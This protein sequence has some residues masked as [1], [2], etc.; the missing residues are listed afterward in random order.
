MILSLFLELAFEPMDCVAQSIFETPTALFQPGIHTL[1]MQDFGMLPYGRAEF[2]S[3]Y[4]IGLG[5]SNFG[6]E[7]YRE[8]ELV[9][10]YARAI[11]IF[12]IGASVRGMK[13]G[14]KGYNEKSAIS[15]GMGVNLQLNKS[16]DCGITVQNVNSPELNSEIIPRTIAYDFTFHPINEF[17][18]TVQ[19]YTQ[20]Y[21]SELR[22]MNEIKLSD[23]LSLNIG[24]KNEPVSFTVGANFNYKKLNIFYYTRTHPELGLTNILGMEIKI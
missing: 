21:S 7:T 15:A 12:K 23:M 17:K 1:W 13:V 6:T 14:I 18:T 8:N 10:G 2:Y 22:L 11:K 9:I 20:D 19:F 4:K 24:L 16:I 3:P 5:I